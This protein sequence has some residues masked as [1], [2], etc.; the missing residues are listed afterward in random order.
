VGKKSS[1]NEEGSMSRATT[2]EAVTGEAE[3][4]DAVQ[5]VVARAL[6]GARGVLRIEHRGEVYTLRITRNDRLILTK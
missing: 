5:L 1:E 3:P 2:P 4:S 6:L